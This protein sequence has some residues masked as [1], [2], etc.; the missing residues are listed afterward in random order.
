[1]HDGPAGGRRRRKEN[2]AD[3][4]NRLRNEAFR[5][6]GVTG[7][8]DENTLRTR[9]HPNRSQEQGRQR[10]FESPGSIVRE[11]QSVA[12]RSA[13]LW[14]RT[15]E[16]V[17]NLP[18]LWQRLCQRSGSS[19]LTHHIVTAGLAVSVLTPILTAAFSWLGADAAAVANQMAGISIGYWAD[20]V[21]DW[22]RRNPGADPRDEATMSGA[23]SEILLAE[24]SI[25]ENLPDADTVSE[26]RQHLAVLLA[27]PDVLGMIMTVAATHG[28]EL[29]A[30][31]P[32]ESELP[33]G[34]TVDDWLLEEVIVVL[35]DLANQP[36]LL[37]VSL[38]KAFRSAA[39]AK[40]GEQ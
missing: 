19:R 6:D 29:L 10:S 36:N 2:V 39:Q 32:P 20:R 27:V 21:T 3:L 15:A 13:E 38:E 8:A 40:I 31:K 33:P 24:F 30:M 4:G 16:S 28:R 12:P 35:E 17:Q 23:L 22:L 26:G 11:S 5:K 34:V 9:E 14:K 37:A 7:P 18:S 25:T 1:M